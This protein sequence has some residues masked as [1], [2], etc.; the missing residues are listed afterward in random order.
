MCCFFSCRKDATL[1][2]VLTTLRLTA[3]HSAEIKHPLA[4]FTFR[5]LYADAANRG[6]IAHRDLGTVY[7]RDILGEP[8]TLTSIAPRLLEDT[9]SDARTDQSTHE[10]GERTLEELRFVPGDYLCISV[11]LPKSVA[12]SEGLG[13]RNNIGNGWKSARPTSPGAFTGPGRGGGHWRGGADSGRGRGRVVSERERTA[14]RDVDRDVDDRD[15]RAPPPRRGRESP[16]L[17]GGFGRDAGRDRDRR[18]KSRSRSFS[19]PRR[20]NSRYD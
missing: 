14:R 1:R 20:R 10:H 5:A 7:S 13:A 4:R 15:R 3:P 16:P 12:Q 9:D 17:R 19:P 18:S 8:G 6:R 2:E 11:I